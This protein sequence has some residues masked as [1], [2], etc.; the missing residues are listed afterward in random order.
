MEVPLS[1]VAVVGVWVRAHRESIPSLR[2]HSLDLGPATRLPV[3][4]CGSMLHP[5]RRTVRQYCAQSII[6]M[7]WTGD[8]RDARSVCSRETI[9]TLYHD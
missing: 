4:L 7:P 2:E 9:Q 8:G 3:L 5:T 1:S 6:I